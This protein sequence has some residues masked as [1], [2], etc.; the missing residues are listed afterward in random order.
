MGVGFLSASRQKPQKSLQG[1][2]TFDFT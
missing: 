2:L 1:R